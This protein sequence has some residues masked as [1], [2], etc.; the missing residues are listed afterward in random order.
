MLMV[1]SGI[2]VNQWLSWGSFPH[3]KFITRRITAEINRTIVGIFGPYIVTCIHYIPLYIICIL[4][5]LLLL[6]LNI[7]ICIGWE[8]LARDK[9]Q[10]QSHILEMFCLDHMGQIGLFRLLYTFCSSSWYC[11]ASGLL[12]L[13]C[14]VYYPL[15]LFAGVCHWALSLLSQPQGAQANPEVSGLI[16]F[17][18]VVCVVKTY[19][20]IILVPP[21][22]LPT[23]HEQCYWFRTTLGLSNAAAHANGLWIE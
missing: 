11:R 15:G 4:R 12:F 17:G 3:A 16:V 21:P 10:S 14:F 8:N 23:S 18:E 9:R 1:S 2:L 7:I 13:L 19:S 5:I 20:K 6:L 22:Y